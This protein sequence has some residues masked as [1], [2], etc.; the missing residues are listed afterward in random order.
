MNRLPGLAW[1]AYV[2]RG[3]KFD[4]TFEHEVRMFYNDFYHLQLTDSQL[5]RLVA[6]P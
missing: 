1:L 6:S 4:A 2:A 3:Q 5:Q